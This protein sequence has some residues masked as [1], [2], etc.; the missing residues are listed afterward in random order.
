MS[1]KIVT[2]KAASQAKTIEWKAFHVPGSQPVRTESGPQSEQLVARIREL[3][4]AVEARAHE[5]YQRGRRE[6]EQ[7]AAE[8][9]EPAV[10]RF[11][12]SAQELASARPRARREAEEDV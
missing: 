11:A 9:L 6:G 8:R 12:I 2:G 4:A 7:Q 1:S 3:E 10:Q 5:A